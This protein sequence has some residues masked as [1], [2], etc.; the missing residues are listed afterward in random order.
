MTFRFIHTSD[1]HLGRRFAN[2]PQPPD[3]NI[4]GRLM[5]ARHSS[6]SKLAAVARDKNARDIFLAGDTLPGNHDN[7]TDAEPLWDKIRNEAPEN[8]HVLAENAPVEFASGVSLLPCPVTHRSSGRD[9]TLDLPSV[10]TADGNVRIGLAH[11][12]VVDFIN[13]GAHIPPDRDRSAGLDYLALG[14]WHGR[15]AVGERTHYSGSPEQDRF[16]HAK[17]GVC[18]AV[19][20]DTA[21]A[22]PDVEDVETGEFLWGKA[23]ITLVSDTDPVEAL[24]TALPDSDRRNTLIEVSVAGRTSLA[25]Q[26]ELQSAAAKLGPDFGCLN[27]RLE[28]LGTEYEATDLDEIDKGGALRLAANQLKED[29]ESEGLSEGDR[30]VSAGALS[31]LYSYIRE[32]E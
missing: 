21:G 2:I 24:N 11:G 16:K 3:G 32:A 15:I 18:L 26:A 27:L 17:R 30:A 12:G 4:R 14:D 5:E 7:L 19:S 29:A 10:A 6:L 1:L 23:E 28:R 20:L 25:K 13:S 31:R 22:P 9:P 8:I